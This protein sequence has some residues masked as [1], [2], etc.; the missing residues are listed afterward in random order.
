MMETNNTFLNEKAAEN[1]IAEV[2]NQ[3]EKNV[4]YFTNISMN[5]AMNPH[6]S[7]WMM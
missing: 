4:E 1:K 2:V 6:R 7:P 3:T 5:I